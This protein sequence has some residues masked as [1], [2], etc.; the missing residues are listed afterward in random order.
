M[1]IYMLNKLHNDKGKKLYIQDK[2]L[3]FID[4]SNELLNNFNNLNI[5]IKY[6]RDIFNLIESTYDY[7]PSDIAILFKEIAFNIRNQKNTFDINRK[8]DFKKLSNIILRIVINFGLIIEDVDNGKIQYTRIAN[9]PKKEDLAG[10]GLLVQDIRDHIFKH[11]SIFKLKPDTM[12]C[13]SYINKEF[14]INFLDQHNSLQI[15]YSVILK[16]IKIYSI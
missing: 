5:K 15:Y 11:H 16:K 9:N 8:D 4:D 14:H 10:L 12:R 6:Y 1:P 2:D 7:F 3:S 13:K